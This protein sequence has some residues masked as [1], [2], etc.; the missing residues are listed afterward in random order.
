M[1]LCTMCKI[2]KSETDYYKSG[3]SSECKECAKKRARLYLYPNQDAP[4]GQKS[5]EQRKATQARYR[6]KNR[7]QI[8]AG[9][10]RYVK[11]NLAKVLARTHKYQAQK[12]NA[13]PKWLTFEHYR[14]MQ[15]IFLKASELSKSLGPHEVDHI[16]PLC[17]DNVCGLHVPWN[18]QI[19]PRAENR[20][21]FNKC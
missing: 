21:K 12:L 9:Q 16:V 7:D 17:G 13:T 8:R 10:R 1:K 11:E 4:R 18:L 3:K 5:S 14:Q 20:R 15:D 2:S 19:L 6:E